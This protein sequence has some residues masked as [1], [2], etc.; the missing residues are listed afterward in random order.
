ML[1]RWL[2]IK[3][4]GIIKLEKLFKRLRDKRLLIDRLNM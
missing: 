3:E 1:V 4:T 2:K